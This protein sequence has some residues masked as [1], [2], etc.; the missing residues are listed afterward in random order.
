M[1]FT[2][3]TS[4]FRLTL[5]LPKEPKVAH[6]FFYL[7]LKRSDIEWLSLEEKYFEIM[8]IIFQIDKEGLG[9]IKSKLSSLNSIRNNIIHLKS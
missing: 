2:K 7:P 3:E 5:D 4:E 6:Y 8:P 1:T 9:V